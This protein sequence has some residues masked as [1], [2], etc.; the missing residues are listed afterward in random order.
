MCV[1]AFGI[2]CGGSL[3]DVRRCVRHVCAM[4]CVAIGVLWWAQQFVYV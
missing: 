1:V 4:V 2:V 3:V